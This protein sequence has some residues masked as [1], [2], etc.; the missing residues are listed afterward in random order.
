[1]ANV[2][3][4]TTYE[5]I[6]R[7]RELW[8]VKYRAA[9]RQSELINKIE[10]I[11]GMSAEKLLELFAAGWTLT[12]PATSEYTDMVCCAYKMYEVGLITYEEYLGMYSNFVRKAKENE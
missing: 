8:N 5:K 12:P 3:E 1:M 4:M 11:T 7:L 9:L 6:E 2:D 10:F